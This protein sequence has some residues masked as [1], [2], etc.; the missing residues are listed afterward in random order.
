MLQN[1]HLKIARFPF[2]GGYFRKRE[3]LDVDVPADLDQ[4]R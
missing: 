4:F 3:K 1:A 2:K